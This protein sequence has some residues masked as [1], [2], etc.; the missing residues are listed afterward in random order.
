MRKVLAPSLFC[1]FIT[2]ITLSF[3]SSCTKGSLPLV[4]DPDNPGSGSDTT[5]VKDTT[6]KDTIKPPP[7]S[8]RILQLGS[9]SG[10]LTIDGNNLTINGTKVTFKN[11]DLV[12]I[13]GGSYNSITIRNVSV[14]TN[15]ARV[16]FI[17][18]GL[19]A[20]TGGKILSLSNL[21]NVTIS[22]AGQSSSGRGFA[23][24]NSTYRA[25]M[26]SGSI[27]N[28]TLQNMLFKNVSD[29]VISY[30]DLNS[31]VYTGEA[32]SFVSNLAFL[33]IDADNVGPL[34]YL[35]GDVSSNSFI[36]LIRKLEIANLTCINSPSPG[37]VVSVGNVEDFDIHDNYVNNV[38]S[39]NTNHNGIF[40]VRGNGK[41]YHNKVTNHQGNAIRSWPYSITKSGRVEIH[42]NVVYNSSQYSAFELGAQP[43]IRASSVYKP[44]NAAVYNNTVGRMNTGKSRFPGRVLDTYTTDGV[45]DFYNNLGF[46]LDGGLLINAQGE[47]KA[48]VGANNIYKNSYLEAVG[49]LINFVSKIAGAGAK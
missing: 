27:N 8:G 36:G 49:D 29:Y 41:F 30:V 15:G 34:I 47:T 37:S 43:Y 12:K 11:G 22:G 2:I 44:A 26:L 33:N 46:E 7:S 24:T 3:T 38:N 42:D 35:G 48:K 40:F 18:D 20:F 6:I 1:I 25:I 10:N 19:V 14:P 4:P 21:N 31:K 32:N 9:G 13:K 23:F 39:N 45:I 28:F 16:T 5:I 17:N